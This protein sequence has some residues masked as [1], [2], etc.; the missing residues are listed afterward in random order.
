[1]TFN[2]FLAD[3]GIWSGVRIQKASQWKMTCLTFC[4]PIPKAPETGSQQGFT[5]QQT[6][7]PT[8]KARAQWIWG[9]PGYYLEMCGPW[10][11]LPGTA[12]KRSSHPLQTMEE[13]VS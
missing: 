7:G 9:V 2:G 1:M 5:I 12:E 3:P 8:C 6:E 4:H 13:M 10:G 11:G